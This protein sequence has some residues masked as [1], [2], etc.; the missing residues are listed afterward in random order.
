MERQITRRGDSFDIG[1]DIPEDNEVP[2]S[3]ANINPQQLISN[4]NLT[5][6]QAENVRALITG[7]GAGGGYKFLSKYLGDEV[8]GAIG[9]FLGAYVAKRVVK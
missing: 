7:A 2:A 4:L 5:P 3:L 1:E 9:G 8:A 6:E